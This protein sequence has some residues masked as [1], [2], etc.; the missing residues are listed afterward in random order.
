MSPL[1]RLYKDPIYRRLRTTYIGLAAGK[2][3]GERI[4]HGY[5]RQIEIA[6]GKRL[7]E[8]FGCGE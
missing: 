2:A 7:R 3:L 5:A 8:F 1:Q 6:L 4:D